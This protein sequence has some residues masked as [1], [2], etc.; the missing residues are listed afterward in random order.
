MSLLG[1]HPDT[2]IQKDA[3]IPAF[4]A[5]KMKKQPKCTSADKWTKKMRC[6]Y[7]RW[8]ITQPQKEW[9]NAICSNME[10]TRE[11][12]TKWTKSEQER[13]IP[14]DI[15][16]IWNLKYDPN[17]PIYKRETASW[18]QRTE[19]VGGGMEWEVGTSRCKLLSRERVNNKIFVYS[20][21]N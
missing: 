7:M 9:N 5:A 6:I 16:Y 1:L 18:T 8:N 13:Q 20:T 15:T 19:E 2:T 4:T 21:G 10:A 17:Q 11:Y 3:C 14:Y 12:H